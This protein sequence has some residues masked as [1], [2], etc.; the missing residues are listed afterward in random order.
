MYSYVI[1]SVYVI[2]LI[3][4]YS[5][6][7]S[8][9]VA[10]PSDG[11]V[12]DS[13]PIW[14]SDVS[15]TGDE[16]NIALCGSRGWGSHD[17][18]H[19]QDAAVVCSNDAFQSV[20]SSV[21]LVDGDSVSNGRVQILFNG[22]W[23]RVCDSYWDIRDGNV[24]CKQLGYTGV[25]SIKVFT[26]PSSDH[27]NCVWMDGIHCT[28]LEKNLSYCGFNGWG[29]AD[30]GCHDAGVDC[31]VYGSDSLEGNYQ[32]RLRDGS[33]EREGRVEIFY[34]GIWGTVCDTRWTIRHG[35]VACRQLGYTHAK[36]IYG[37]SWY[38]G[39]SG[40][41]LMDVVECQ[42][43]ESRL[44]DCSFRGWGIVNDHCTSHARDVSVQC[45]GM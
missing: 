38:G 2:L 16:S 10:T 34:S 30:L 44:V 5:S 9:R 41:V 43:D 4:G 18:S 31:E 6:V 36:A 35:N 40:V 11:M 37:D 14:L 7:D 3:S 8:I 21:R 19:D 12:S 1:R 39:G 15:C 45:E 28:G 17:C 33:S 13:F 24:V 20:S 26:T 42:G 22:V 29:H 27:L 32:I 25:K 23:G